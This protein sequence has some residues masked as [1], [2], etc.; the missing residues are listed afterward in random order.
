MKQPFYAA[1]LFTI[2][3]LVHGCSSDNQRINLDTNRE[4]VKKYHEVWSSGEVAALDSIL[5]PDF[6][7]H[8]IDGV[9]WKGIE[10][11]KN[12]II[13]HRESFPDWT[14]EIVD[15]ISEG[16]KVVT[17]YKSAG[18]QQGTFN[19]LDSSGKKRPFMKPLFTG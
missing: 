14:E 16:D 13:S 3:I 5:T 1:S 8:F 10:G 17:R 18:T 15:M 19:G 6:V 2:S 9:E 4:V 12:S 11:A 7:C